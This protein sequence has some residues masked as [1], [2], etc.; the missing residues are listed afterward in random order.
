MQMSFFNFSNSISLLPSPSPHPTY[1]GKQQPHLHIPRIQVSQL[2]MNELELL[3]INYAKT[4]DQLS[5]IF[6]RV[7]GRG[8]GGGWMYNHLGPKEHGTAPRVT[9][10]PLLSSHLF[11]SNMQSHRK[12][13]CKSSLIALDLTPIWPAAPLPTYFK[14]KSKS[15]LNLN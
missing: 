11:R 13:I 10:R 7:G 1:A 12:S 15:N 9:D 14:L 2:A 8:G 6:D 5:N 4:F 3:L